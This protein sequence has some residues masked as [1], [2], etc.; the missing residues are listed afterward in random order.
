MPGVVTLANVIFH[1][2]LCGEAIKNISIL[3]KQAL[4][5]VRNLCRIYKYVFTF[6]HTCSAT[7]NDVFFVF[8]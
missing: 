3:Q 2:L 4:L 6:H 1:L 7:N 8:K 5:G